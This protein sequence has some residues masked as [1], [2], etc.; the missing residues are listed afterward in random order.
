[1][2]DQVIVKNCWKW[3]EKKKISCESSPFDVTQTLRY[4]TL[5]SWEQLD[6]SRAP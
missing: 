1:M 5:V 3:E 2:G 6:S 4:K